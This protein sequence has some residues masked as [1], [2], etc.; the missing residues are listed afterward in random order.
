MR[1]EN[2]AFS[3]SASVFSAALVTCISVSFSKASYLSSSSFMRH[4]RHIIDGFERGKRAS[5]AENF[6]SIVDSFSSSMSSEIAN[7]SILLTEKQRNC[8]KNVIQNMMT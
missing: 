6:D 7:V 3:T 1:V 5:R 2:F 4:I 8:S